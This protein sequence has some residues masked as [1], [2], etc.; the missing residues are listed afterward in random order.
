[1]YSLG[2]RNAGFLPRAV[3]RKAALSGVA[4]SLA[5]PLA[6]ENVL[7]LLRERHLG[8]AAAARESERRRLLHSGPADATLKQGSLDGGFVGVHCES[9]RADANEG[10]LERD[11]EDVTVAAR[12]L[13]RHPGEKEL[14]LRKARVVFTPYAREHGVQDDLAFALGTLR[15]DEREDP[16]T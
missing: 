1:M 3:G 9:K 12:A 15:N 16:M 10:V 4:G 13:H 5:L 6:R 14:G 8:P 2:P 11:G 7:Q